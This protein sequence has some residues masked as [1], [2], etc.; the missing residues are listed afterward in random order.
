VAFVVG[1]TGFYFQAIEKGL[2]PV[3]AADPQMLAQVE[4]ELESDPE[5]LYAELVARD[6]EAAQKISPNDHYRLARAIELMRSH[7][8]TVTEIRREFESQEKEFPFALMKIGL[9][10]SRAEL[11]PVVEKRTAD[12]LARGWI[13]E[14]EG[15]LLRGLREWA[16]LSSVGYKEIAD[17]LTGRSEAQNSSELE[18]MIVQSTL[19]LAKKQRTWFQR[20]TDIHWFSAGDLTPAQEAIDRFLGREK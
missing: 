20:D 5:R 1:G 8:R 7:G 19:Q 16:P 13:A 10:A 18:A 9:K 2:Y 12:M 17:Y 4:K 3:G 15:L 6:P 11:L 14:V